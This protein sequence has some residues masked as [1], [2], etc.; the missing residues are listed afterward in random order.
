MGREGGGVREEEGGNAL[1]SPTGGN[2]RCGRGKEVALIWFHF[3]NLLSNLNFK[4]S[5][6]G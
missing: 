2:M 4:S 1:W 5:K 3:C 6:S